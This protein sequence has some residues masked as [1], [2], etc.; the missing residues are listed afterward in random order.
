M[1][2][3]SA[4]CILEGQSSWHANANEVLSQPIFMQTNCINEEQN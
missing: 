2:K 3:A 1:H 4:N